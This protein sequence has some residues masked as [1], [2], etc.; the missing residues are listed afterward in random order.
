MSST[1]NLSVTCAA[2]Q[3]RFRYNVLGLEDQ[4]VFFCLHRSEKQ[5]Y[6]VEEDRAG[7][8]NVL[9]CTSPS[10]QTSCELYHV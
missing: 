8:T 5:S 6:L 2:H 4:L 10:P 1:G 9:S 3:T 7:N